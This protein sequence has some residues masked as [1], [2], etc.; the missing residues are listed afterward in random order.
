MIRGKPGRQTVDNN[1]DA[2][3]SP[4]DFL[5]VDFAEMEHVGNSPLRAKADRVHASEGN[6]R[7]RFSGPLS[8]PQEEVEEWRKDRGPPVDASII[9]FVKNRMAIETGD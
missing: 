1:P 6:T 7:M 9:T 8:A 2:P 5:H 3:A 4:T